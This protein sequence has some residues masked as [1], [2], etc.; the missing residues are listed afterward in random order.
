MARV[1]LA[2]QDVAQAQAQ[3][4]HILAHLKHGILDGT[5]EPFRV[6]LTCYQ[7][8]AA[9]RDPRAQP[10]LK[11]AVSLLRERAAQIANLDLRRS[12]LVRVP[13]NR[14]LLAAWQ[15]IATSASDPNAV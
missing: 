11:T 14:A 5:N 13:A 6:Y 15:A 9:S 8:L 10:L 2:N 7:V 1:F 12:F 4:E 3:V